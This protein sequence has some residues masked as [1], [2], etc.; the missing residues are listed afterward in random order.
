MCQAWAAL[1]D[2]P[3]PQILL[4]ACR[5]QE[6]CKTIGGEQLAG[7]REGQGAVDSEKAL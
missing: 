7:K 6:L 2:L 5:S 1:P 3:E 4:P